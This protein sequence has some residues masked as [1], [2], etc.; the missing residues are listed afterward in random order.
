MKDRDDT[1]VWTLEQS[2]LIQSFC[3]VQ[4]MFMKSTVQLSIEFLITGEIYASE[5]SFGHH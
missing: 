4:M 5:I 1:V 2:M 3:R